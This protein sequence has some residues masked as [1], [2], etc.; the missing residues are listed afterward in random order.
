MHRSGGKEFQVLSGIKDTL[1]KIFILY[2]WERESA[3]RVRAER[4]GETESKA[5]SR[6]WAVSTEPEVGL[7]LMNRKFMTWAEVRCSI[8]WVTQASPSIHFLKCLNPRG[9]PTSGK[10]AFEGS[11]G[12]SKKH[13]LNV[14]TNQAKRGCSLPAKTRGER[15]RTMASFTLQP[16]LARGSRRLGNAEGR[17][18]KEHTLPIPLPSD[19][20]RA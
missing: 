1:K 4:E 12:F 14:N 10:C 8:N 6:L 19:G 11:S 5:G 16:A 17:E 15:S 13:T 20:P 7:K 18:G 9:S 2:F 3:S